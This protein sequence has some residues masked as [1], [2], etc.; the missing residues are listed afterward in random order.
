MQPSSSPSTNH[1][2]STSLTAVPGST[3]ATPESEA[4]SPLTLSRTLVKP[5]PSSLPAISGFHYPVTRKVDVTDN[6]HGLDVADP[7]RWL[8]DDNSEATKAW[9]TAQNQVTMAY[10]EAIPQR[11]AIQDRLSR[12][13]NYQRFGVPARRGERY[14]FRRND[15][16]QNQDVIYMSASL[17]ADPVIAL[18]PNTLSEDGTVAVPS[19]AVSEDGRHMA[20][21]VARSGSDWR[22]IRVRD[23]DSG[24]DLDDHVEWVKFS[25]ISWKKDGSGFYYSRYDQPPEG[26][27]FTQVNEYNKLYF[28]ALGTSQAEDP[29]VYERKDEPKWG[30]YGEVTESGD[31]LIIHVTQGTDRR[32]RIFYLDLNEPDAA[33]VELLNAFDASYSFIENDGTVFWFHTDL[34]APRGKVIAVDIAQ[35]EAEHWKELIPEKEGTLSSVQV[36]GDHFLVN[37]LQDAR[38]RVVRHRLDGVEVGEVSLPGLG[39]ASGFG[40]RRDRTETFYSFSS[41]TTPTTIHRYDVAT[42]EHSVWRRPDVAFDPDRYETRQVWV[43][44]RDG[45]RFPMFLTHRRGLEPDGKTPTLLYG[46]GGFNI[47]ITPS[48]RVDTAVWLD[49]GGMYAVAN[50]RGGGEYGEDWHRAGT[51][52]EKQN[53][54]NDFIAAA[55]WLIAEK[56]T[57]SSHLAIRGGS[58]G[59]LLVGACMTQRPEL[60]GACLPAVGVMD[61]LR[62]HRFTIGW[63]WVSDYGSSEDPEEF[64]AL[65]AYSP[66]HNLKPGTA[67]PPT[68]ITTADHDDR[69]VPAHSF[70]FAARLQETHSGPNPVLIRIETRAG[71]GAGKPVSKQIE[72]ST[73]ILAFLAH[74]FDMASPQ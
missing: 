24:K 46:Y 23:L 26:Q 50:I 4:G 48:F 31:Y 67:Y 52:L 32:N 42:D 14:F 71:H 28:H 69:V 64:K 35:A 1:E 39:T 63:A 22:E 60:F 2:V 56:Y 29:L 53:V 16:L 21:S 72:E 41:F 33:V 68:L 65:Y 57:Q 12:L 15:G 30:F 55:E 20:Y 8:E 19:F 37:Y 9:V 58:N 49:M 43:T 3:Q 66:Y 73:D 40:G 6:Y 70:K 45:T 7:Y 17:D 11:S 51:K 13:I 38:S 36:V 25:G 74:Q 34:N 54:F 5:V 44:S 27:E 62:F 47:S 10:L 61:M 59:G 18:D